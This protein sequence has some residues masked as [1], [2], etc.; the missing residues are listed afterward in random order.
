VPVKGPE[1]SLLPKIRSIPSITFVI[2]Q[3]DIVISLDRACLMVADSQD[4]LL[5][6]LNISRGTIDLGDGL[7]VSRDWYAHLLIV[8]A[9]SF[10]VSRP[11]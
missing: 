6:R 2:Y 8:H 4:I 7:P 9:V 10:S 1:I 5:V 3:S 11:F